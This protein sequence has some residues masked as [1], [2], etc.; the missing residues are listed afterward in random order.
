MRKEKFAHCPNDLT[1]PLPEL[2][3]AIAD[4][5]Y[6]QFG[7]FPGGEMPAFFQIVPVRD[8]FHML[9]GPA[10]RGAENF[11][12]VHADAH[13]QVHIGGAKRAAKACAG[14]SGTA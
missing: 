11:L 4:F 1:T 12:W 13:R 14:R 5:L 6:E 2:P 10:A 7:L 9:L 8:V 3:E